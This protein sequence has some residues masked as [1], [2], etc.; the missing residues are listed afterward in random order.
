MMTAP[1]KYFDLSK[2]VDPTK[3]QHVPLDDWDLDK[4]TGASDVKAKAMPSPIEAHGR[5]GTMVILTAGAIY[6]GT[7]LFMVY[8][9]K[10][11]L[12]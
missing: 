2:A 7:V 12:G 11:A 3:A 4:T 5:C 10:A 9:A 6:M 1:K 8:M